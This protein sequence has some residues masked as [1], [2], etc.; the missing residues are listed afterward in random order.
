VDRQHLSLS[1]LWETKFSSTVRREAI[2]KLTSATAQDDSKWRWNILQGRYE[3]GER[4]A[5][6]PMMKMARKSIEMLAHSALENQ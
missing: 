4:E 3:R 6:S 5:E 1:Q 2:R